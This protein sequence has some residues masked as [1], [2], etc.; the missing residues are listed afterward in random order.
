MIQIAERMQRGT[1]K[2]RFRNDLP[3]IEYRATKR[4]SLTNDQQHWRRQPYST[5]AHWGLP[6]I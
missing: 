1:G 5:G 2:T 4:C 6:T 3:S